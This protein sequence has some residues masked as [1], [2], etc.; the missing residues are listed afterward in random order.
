MEQEKDEEEKKGVREEEE[1][2][3]SEEREVVKKGDKE[4][5]K[6]KQKRSQSWKIGFSL[7]PSCLCLLLLNLCFHTCSHYL[8][9]SLFYCEAIIN[10]INIVHQMDGW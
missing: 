4:E 6:S 1:E 7:L 9:C 5:D 3:G 2:E 10:D 8:C